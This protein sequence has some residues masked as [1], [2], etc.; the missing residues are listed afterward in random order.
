MSSTALFLKVLMTVPSLR[1]RR[2]L[3][4]RSATF[5]FSLE[6]TFKLG[7]EAGEKVARAQIQP[8]KQAY[9]CGLAPPHSHL[10]L[11][12]A[13][14]WEARLGTHLFCGG[15][16]HHGCHRAQAKAVCRR[17]ASQGGRSGVGNSGPKKH[18]GL[19]W[20]MGCGDGDGEISRLAPSQLDL[21][22]STLHLCSDHCT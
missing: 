21:P 12:G 6:R 1:R 19:P 9:T 3:L 2:G 18:G 11:Q 5:C 20:G 4:L 16:S 22:P 13:T 10:Y 17:V 7:S 8:H 15:G 14:C